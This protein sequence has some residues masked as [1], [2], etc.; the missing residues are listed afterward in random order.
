[1][2]ISHQR[3]TC[4]SKW[5]RKVCKASRLPSAWISPPACSFCRTISISR[6]SALAEAYGIFANNGTLAGQAI[7]NSGL[8]SIAVLEV[9]SVDHS[10]WADWT[11][12]QTRLLLSPQLDYLMNQVLS[13]ETARWP[14]LGHPNPLEI[15]RPAGAKLSHALD[16]S[17]AWTVG[18]TP[19][20]VAVVWLGTGLHGARRSTAQSASEVSSPVPPRLSADLWHALM[21]YAVRDLPSA[22]WDMP[23]GIVTVAVC[24]PSGL[25]PTQACPNV[26]NE[27]FLEGRQ[28]VQTDTL[29]QTFQVNTET[30]LLATVFTPPE[31]VEKRTYMVVPPEARLWAKTAG[32]AAPANSI[33]TL[34]RSRRCCR[35]CTSPHRR[36]S[37]TGAPSS[38]SAA[39]RPARTSPGT[40]WNTARAFTRQLGADRRR[41]PHAGHGRPAG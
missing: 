18:Y 7:G 30:G 19:Q 10:I 24:D 4:S 16:L 17:G 8:H 41:Q 2:T 33:M 23:S 34:S 3:W 32:I 14:S 21:Q 6:R 28:P 38:K 11:A 40:G 25:L 15:G 27:I 12:S 35:T 20:R 13:D 31:L 29:Y 26:V 22:S 5:G 1:M 9:S 36:C 37:Q 39:A